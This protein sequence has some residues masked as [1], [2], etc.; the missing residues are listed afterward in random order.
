MVVFLY[1]FAKPFLVRSGEA[2]EKLHKALKRDIAF[3]FPVDNCQELVV[4]MFSLIR[5]DFMDEAAREI[6]REI[7]KID[8]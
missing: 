8:H 6:C 5:P 2:E 7:G 1:P 3:C 4:E